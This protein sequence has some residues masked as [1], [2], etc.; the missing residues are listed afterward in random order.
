MKFFFTFHFKMNRL[1]EIFELESDLNCLQREKEI[2]DTEFNRR[3]DELLQLSRNATTGE[4]HTELIRQMVE[5]KSQYFRQNDKIKTQIYYTTH[6]LNR[7]KS[8]Q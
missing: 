8:E 6:A 3:K 4:R 1:R 5:L 2:L 7:K